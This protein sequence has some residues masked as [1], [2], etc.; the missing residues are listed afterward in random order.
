MNY[1]VWFNVNRWRI[2]E[3]TKAD[4]KR[5]INVLYYIKLEQRFNG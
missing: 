3:G 1:D 4:C 2:E 5:E